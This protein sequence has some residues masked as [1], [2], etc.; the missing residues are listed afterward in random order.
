MAKDDKKGGGAGRLKIKTTTVKAK[1]M[2]PDKHPRTGMPVEAYATNPTLGIS[3]DQKRILRTLRDQGGMNAREIAELITEGGLADL[4]P[5]ARKMRLNATRR[6]MEGLEAR[7]LVL[8]S[9]A[10][11]IAERRLRSGEVGRSVYG[12][13]TFYRIAPGMAKVVKQL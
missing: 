13:I 1:R 12:T 2:Q 9:D 3:K 7:G 5:K 10:P 8:V 11:N 6:T 4:E